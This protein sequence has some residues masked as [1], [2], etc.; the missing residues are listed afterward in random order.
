[1]TS[2]RRQRRCAPRLPTLGLLLTLAGT[3]VVWAASLQDLADRL[4]DRS[5]SHVRTA[6]LTEMR[7]LGA[8]DK[9]ALARLLLAGLVRTD[10]YERMN[11]ATA[12]G[13]LDAHARPVRDQLRPLLQDPSDMV[14]REAQAAL[15]RLGEDRPGAVAAE[16]ANYD[17]LR[18]AQDVETRNARYAAIRRLGY[19]LASEGERPP[20]GAVTLAEALGD[21]DAYTRTAAAQ[22]LFQVTRIACADVLPVT[23]ALAGAVR[24]ADRNTAYLA[25]RTLEAMGLV[26]GERKDEQAR[27][28]SSND[29]AE[30]RRLGQQ[31]AR[32]LA[33]RNGPSAC[34]DRPPS[35]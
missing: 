17:R 25:F 16:V 2:P 23:P 9:D 30:R 1:M 19:V 18:G 3:G 11:A 14:R 13:F 15:G 4:V 22:G 28:A 6:A 35:R 24:D 20:A 27:A 26:R 5:R 10:P 34:A 32:D 7:Q 12:L 33:V 29:G 31:I 8:A 21:A